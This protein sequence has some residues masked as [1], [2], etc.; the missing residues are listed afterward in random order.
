MRDIRLLTLLPG[1]GSTPI[2]IDIKTARLTEGEKPDYE[3]LSYVWGSSENLSNIVVGNSGNATLAITQNLATALPYLRLEDRPRVLWIDAICIDQKNLD[4]RSHQVRRMSDIY[5]MATRVVVWLGP[6]GD[7]STLAL[8][9]MDVLSSQIEVDWLA[10]RLKPSLAGDV[11]PRFA[12]ELY[13]IPYEE[14]IWY[15]IYDL[16]NRPWF[17]RLWVRQEVRFQPDHQ[18]LMCGTRVVHWQKFRKAVFRLQR[19]A[20]PSYIANIQDRFDLVRPLCDTDGRLP[21]CHLIQQTK[22]C[23]CLDPRDRLYALLSMI[24]EPEI[25]IGIEPDYTKSI[26]QVYMDVV[27]K[28]LDLRRLDILFAC[29]M[30][31]DRA[32][33][34]SWVPDLSKAF[35]YNHIWQPWASGNVEADARRAGGLALEVMGV[36][37]ATVRSVTTVFS[38]QHR[39][40]LQTLEAIR[41]LWP[42]HIDRDP[43]VG[44]GSVF[45]AFLCTLNANMFSGRWSPPDT[46]RSD[47]N[48]T[49]AAVLDILRSKQGP[50]KSFPASIADYLTMVDYYSA[51]R[52]IFATQEGYIGLAPLVAQEGDQV[53]VIL[54]CGSPL[55][56]REVTEGQYWV[57]GECYVHG[58]MNAEAILGSLPSSFQQVTIYDSVVGNYCPGFLDRHTGNVQI[59]DPRLEPLPS[60]W[61]LAQHDRCYSHHLRII[62]D[63]E[64]AVDSEG[65]PLT[66]PRFRREGLEKRGV[67]L[68]WFKLV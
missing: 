21:L 68:R 16:L 17:E 61:R 62:G 63:D 19:N 33:L 1:I 35:Q 38:H 53:C 65:R 64:Q 31:D 57:L 36:K 11:D 15:A 5:T 55:L 46:S 12:D 6:E 25:R 47:L 2:S 8:S 42:L 10:A 27:L 18:V 37:S 39:V 22:Q 34:P 7:N 43:Y 60:E 54:G 14:K 41:R 56:L 59:T 45:D 24:R 48:S 52:S 66:G 49:R 50:L 28:S 40:G 4:E 3:A 67:N 30:R 9:T 29:E 26:C 20:K 23:S 51:G 44:G 58:L 13:D 32:N